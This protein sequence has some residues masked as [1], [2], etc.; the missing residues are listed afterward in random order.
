MRIEE[1]VALAPLTTLG[2][3]GRARRVVTVEMV[4]ELPAVFETTDPVLVLGGGS[5]L[6]VR[7]GGWSGT[8]V[9][10]ALAELSSHDDTVTAAAGIDWDGFVA[11]VVDDGRVGVECLAGTP[12]LVGATPMQNVGAYGQE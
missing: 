9:R 4:D 11:E 8:V 10:I 12:G 2:V 5:N 7:D 6:V 1:D 3:G